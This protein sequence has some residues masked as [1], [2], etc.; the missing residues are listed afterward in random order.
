MKAINSKSVEYLK[1]LVG[2]DT[3]IV[4]MYVEGKW[5]CAEIQNT[6]GALGKSLSAPITFKVINNP[7]K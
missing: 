6:G 3:K 7:F 5:L 4:D 1:S 2:K